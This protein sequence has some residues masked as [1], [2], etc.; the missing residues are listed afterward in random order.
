MGRA[1]VDVV[2]WFSPGVAPPAQLPSPFDQLGPHPLVTPAVE[3][4]KGQLQS[5]SLREGKMFGVLVVRSPEGRLGFL[6]AFSGMLDGAWLRAGFCAPLFDAEAREALEGAGE[7]MISALTARLAE[8][9]ASPAWERARQ[10]LAEVRARQQ[11][12]RGELQERHRLRRADR[13]QRRALTAKAA[14]REAIDNESR[15]D[16]AE[17]RRLDEA[18]AAELASA[19]A[20]LA[21]FE[22]RGRALERLRAFASRR[23]MQRLHDTYRLRSFDGQTRPLR[24]LFL[25]EPPS[26]AADC[27]GPKLLFAAQ[28]LGLIPVA[29]AELWWGPAP[30][31]GGR[32]QGAFYPACTA[33]CGP[34]LPFMLGGLEVAPPRAFTPPRPAAAGLDLVYEDEALVVL[35]KP[36]GLLSI[37]AK[38]GR[39]DD[40]V[41][42]RLRERYPHA[43]GP[44]IVHRLDLD[45]SGV[46]VAALT[47]EAYAALQRQFLRREVTKRYVAVLGGLVQQ[48]RGRIELPLRVDL[49]DRPRQI[50]DP[51]HGL[52]AI[53]DWEVL[54]R[55]DHT[56]RVAL[57]PLTGR[58]HQLRVH[59]SHPRGLNAPIVGDRLYGHEADR[60]LLHADRL[61]FTHPLSGLRRT[62]EV[63]APF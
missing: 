45:T 43:T 20:S 14:E 2:T 31:T 32:V 49:E 52:K 22:R 34:V 36:H 63:P 25:G 24:A 61:A 27:C 54:S 50:H 11:A 6:R 39:Q 15:R 57:S 48:E 7:R 13:Q 41:L 21:P 38:D 5:L 42:L 17:R 23:L 62:F 12:Q 1:D 46:M 59:A 60:L 47:G 28:R 55:G 40:S 19:Q 51:V 44:L 18:Q 30:Q 35:H 10:T 29:M 53:T 9:R 8:H 37:P 3:A 26:G 4:L 33:K 56:T 58:T 16:K